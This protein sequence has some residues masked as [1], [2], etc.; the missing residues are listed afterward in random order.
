MV[1]RGWLRN[2]ALAF[3]STSEGCRWHRHQQ[4]LHLCPPNPGS[5]WI[6]KTATPVRSQT[7]LLPRLSSTGDGAR[8]KNRPGWPLKRETLKRSLGMGG[9]MALLVSAGGN[10]FKNTFLSLMQI[11]LNRAKLAAPRACTDPSSW[12]PSPLRVPSRTV[13]RDLALA[14]NMGRKQKGPVVRGVD[15]GATNRGIGLACA[16]MCA[17]YQPIHARLQRD[18]F[19]SFP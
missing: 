3:G 13:E 5:K 2:P 11:Q 16:L 4:P 19:Q 17:N 15:P 12:R 7:T 1:P 10:G 9:G 18:C 6:W 14:P 8:G